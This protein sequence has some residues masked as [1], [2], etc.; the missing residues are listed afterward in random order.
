MHSLFENVSSNLMMSL[1]IEKVPKDRLPT[2]SWLLT[3]HQ[4]PIH[5][6]NRT[7]T[8]KCQDWQLLIRMNK[9]KSAQLNQSIYEIILILYIKRF[10]ISFHYRS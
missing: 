7:K 4:L 6:V 10:F 3:L 2:P 5:P 9:E 1:R 8:Q